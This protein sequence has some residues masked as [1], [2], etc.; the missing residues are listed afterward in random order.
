MKLRGLSGFGGKGGVGLLLPHLKRLQQLPE[1]GGPSTDRR[2]RE[3]MIQVLV[4]L[5]RR[6]TKAADE[7]SRSQA[8]GEFEAYCQAKGPAALPYL[9]KVKAGNPVVRNA[10]HWTRGKALYAAYKNSV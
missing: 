8:M 7:T 3:D 10:A 4:Y 1:T 5:Q 2:E 9:E 6:I